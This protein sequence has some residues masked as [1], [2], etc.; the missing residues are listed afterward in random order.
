[1]FSKLP[2][3]PRSSRHK[4]VPHAFWSTADV[5][6]YMLQ[7]LSLIELIGFSHIDRACLIYAKTLLKGRISRYSSPFFTK[8]TPPNPA[9]SREPTLFVRFFQTLEETR[10]WIV[11]SVALAAASVLSDAPCPTNLNIITH[12]R[13]LGAWFRF[14][15]GES[16]FAV[17]TRGWSSGAYAVAGGLVFEFQH[18]GIK[19]S[20]A[21]FIYTYAHPF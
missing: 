13:Q 7:F 21:C 2:S 3:R 8:N 1:M 6:L 17:R 15:V 16:G 18:P 4:R 20:I 11:S 9:I 12:C 14:L 19:V 10:S 5:V